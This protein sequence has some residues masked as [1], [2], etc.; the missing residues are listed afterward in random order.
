VVAPGSLRLD[1]YVTGLAVTVG[2]VVVLL[3]VLLALV[4]RAD[5][6]APARRPT[7]HSDY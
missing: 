1:A 3:M 2:V 6:G 5:L 7:T 4:G